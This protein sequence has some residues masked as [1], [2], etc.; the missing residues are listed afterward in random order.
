MMRSRFVAEVVFLV[1][2]QVDRQG[3]ERAR[4]SRGAIT[5]L[6]AGVVLLVFMFQN[7][8]TVRVRFL[9]FTFSL[10]LWLY[11]FGTAVVGGLLWYGLGLLRRRRGRP[12]H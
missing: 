2:E 7:T 10:P 9:V 3:P 4:L 1:S 11:T 12:T 6:V 8:G 5:A